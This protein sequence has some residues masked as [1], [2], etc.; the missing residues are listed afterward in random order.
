[1][2][3]DAQKRSYLKRKDNYPKIRPSYFNHARHAQDKFKNLG[4]DYT[5]KILKKTT[6]PELYS[7]PLQQSF[8]ERIEGMINFMI[9]QVKYIKKTFSIAH[10]KESI[11]IR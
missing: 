4:Y 2:A 9:E 1:M 5:G 8:F 3:T 11:N 10:E 6:S 7:N